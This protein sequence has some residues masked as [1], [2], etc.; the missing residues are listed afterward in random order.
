MKDETK[1]IEKKQ[2]KKNKKAPGIFARKYKPEKLEKKVYK[3]IYVK[4]DLEY[5]KTL[6]SEFTDKKGRTYLAVPK[7]MR[8]T[9]KEVKRLKKLSVDIKSQKGRVKIVALL[10]TAALIAGISIF[11]ALFKNVLVKKAV[12]A[13]CEAA[14]GAVCDIE[15]VSFKPFAGYL[16]I[17]DIQIADKSSPWTNVIQIEKLTSDFDLTMLLQGK[18][19]VE[20]MSVTGIQTGTER[21]SDGTLAVKE[22]KQK[23]KKE[24]EKPAEPEEPKEPSKLALMISDISDEMYRRFMSAC[25]DLFAQ[26]DPAQIIDSLYGQLS[27][28]ETVNQAMEFGKQMTAELQEKASELEKT[29]D[30]VKK[31]MDEVMAVDYQAVLKNPLL[32]KEDYAIVES[33]YT[34]AVNAYNE[35]TGTISMVSSVTADVQKQYAVLSS[36]VEKDTLFLKSQVDELKGITT[37]DAFSFLT[38]TGADLVKAVLGETYQ[39]VEMGLDYVKNMKK[40]E[41]P[42]SEKKKP[43]ERSQGRTIT[44]RNHNEPKVWIKYLEGSGPKLQFTAMNI[45]SDEKAAGGPAV[46]DFNGHDLAF[47]MGTTS[48]KKMGLSASTAFDV[49]AT[50]HDTGSYEVEGKLALSPFSIYAGTFDPDIASSIV[51][52]VFARFTSA[53]AE[54]TAVSAEKGMKFTF[55]TDIGTNL[56]QAVLDEW[57]EQLSAI[58]EKVLSELQEKLEGYVNEAVQSLTGYADVESAIEEYTAKIESYKK[59]LEDKKNEL[60]GYVNGTMDA[61]NAG[62][63]QL[64]DE[65]ERLKKEAAAA[66]QAE[67]ERLKAE[68]EAAA[69]AEAE[70]LKKE[71]EDAAKAEAERLKKEAE[72]AA[73]REAEAAAQKAAEAA[74]KAFKK[75][76]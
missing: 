18:F 27:V 49:S 71:A 12:K 43:A 62:V 5:V 16:S 11:L 60:T 6:F 4:E 76:W 39:Y 74:S 15:D 31:S 63:E 73:K 2:P 57:N 21:S 45:S 29:A 14:F 54:F 34:T 70:R 40:D 33:A 53:A 41:K 69:K 59:L 32:I 46:L 61:V 22:K 65:A 37:K 44:Y 3:R 48:G 56:Y 7:D 64:K 19:I 51:N 20:E 1:D 35:A 23:A 9:K 42:A 52:S 13:G 47:A 66:A 55:D 75:F 38:D 17:T 24:P 10:V 50:I 67:A 28:P 58:K 36:A 72:D 25:S 68:A 8:F 30:A 26:Y